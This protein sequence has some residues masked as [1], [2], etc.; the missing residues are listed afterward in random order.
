LSGVQFIVGSKFPLGGFVALAPSLHSKG[1]MRGRIKA[2]MKARMKARLKVLTWTYIFIPAF[3]ISFAFAADLEKAMLGALGPNQLNVLA[4]YD[5]GYENKI[6][7][8]ALSIPFALSNLGTP[9]LGAINLET[10]MQSISQVNVRSL[11]W[12]FQVSGSGSDRVTAIHLVQPKTI[13]INRPDMEIAPEGVQQVVAFHESLS[14]DGLVDE[15]MFLSVGSWWLLQQTTEE[16]ARLLE[17]PLLKP[18]W[19]NLSTK[20]NAA[21]SMPSSQRRKGYLGV[22]F[23]FE[24]A[25]GGGSTSVGGGGNW[26][27]AHIKMEMLRL[28]RNWIQNHPKQFPRL[29]KFSGDELYRLTLMSDVQTDF[30]SGVTTVR[31]GKLVEA[32]VQVEFTKNREWLIAIGGYTWKAAEPELRVQLVEY[33]LRKL[34]SAYRSAGPM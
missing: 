13:I 28:A 3:A 17:S 8:Q 32:P 23:E 11:R 12:G 9:S 5:R 16:R 22:T 30:P 20:R 21:Y 33:I 14:A 1:R 31:H 19:T 2:P 6:R 26:D 34:E 15:T 18:L 10:T 29:V 25:G 4:P 24:I 7:G 27:I